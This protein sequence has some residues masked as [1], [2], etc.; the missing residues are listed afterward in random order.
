MSNTPTLAPSAPSHIGPILITFFVTA[1]I[2][3]AIL[4]PLFRWHSGFQ[5]KFCP[6]SNVCPAVTVCP[7]SS[8]RLGLSYEMSDNKTANEFVTLVNSAIDDSIQPM[9]CS[10][11]NKHITSDNV[12]LPTGSC[13]TF[14]DS[15]DTAFNSMNPPTDIVKQYNTF[16]STLTT[17]ICNADDTINTAS[18]TTFSED[19]NKMI[20]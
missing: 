13:K 15:N 14:I 6:A 8:D 1:I 19:I 5:S 12:S 9:L 20:C 16:K 10:A 3:L 4:L 2:V 11:F 17:A 18:L 7:K